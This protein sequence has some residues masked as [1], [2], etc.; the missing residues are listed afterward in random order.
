MART[1]VENC[2]TDTKWCTC[3]HS[4]CW[5]LAVVI[6]ISVLLNSVAT[7]ILLYWSKT[8]NSNLWWI[9]QELLNLEYDK[10][11]WKE[12]YDIITKMQ[13][14]QIEQYVAQYKQQNWWTKWNEAWAT[15]TEETKTE[16]KTLTKDEIA[17]IKQ[18]AYIEW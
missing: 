8:I 15:K 2:A 5:V 18:W 11:W 3:K 1:A 17:G 7:Y 13:K 14:S 9:K 12:N 16:A 6:I 10:V 4:I